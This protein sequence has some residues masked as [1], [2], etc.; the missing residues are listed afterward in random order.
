MAYEVF[1]LLIEKKLVENLKRNYKVSE[2]EAK[3]YLKSEEKYVR[4]KFN[5]TI[6]KIKNGLCPES[7]L[8]EGLPSTIVWNLSMSY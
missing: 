1:Y 5:Y 4:E 3:K 8:S 6:K 7:F 2:E